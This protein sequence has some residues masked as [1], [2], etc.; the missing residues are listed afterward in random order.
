[1]S[2]EIT[3]AVII[4]NNNNFTAIPYQITDFR[5]LAFLSPILIT[6][7]RACFRKVQYSVWAANSYKLWRCELQNYLSLNNK[8]KLTFIST[9]QIDAQLNIGQTTN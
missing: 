1:M 7:S 8:K 4:N 2:T 5:V 6:H 3:C 9:L